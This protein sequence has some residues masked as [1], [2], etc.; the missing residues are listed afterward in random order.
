MICTR[1]TPSLVQNDLSGL[2]WNYPL[3][4][5][6]YLR[7]KGILGIFSLT[8]KYLTPVKY[9]RGEDCRLYTMHIDAIACELKWVVRILIARRKNYEE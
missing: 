5:D 7:H 3:K 9:V 8:Q 2:I 4:Y 1:E 6:D